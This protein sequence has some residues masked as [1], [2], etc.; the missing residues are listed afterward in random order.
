MR[1]VKWTK[2]ALVLAI[3]ALALLL[4]SGSTRTPKV[5][6][7]PTTVLTITNTLCLTLTAT[8]GDWN[9]DTVVDSADAQDGLS[10]CNSLSDAGNMADLVRVLGGDPDHP[11]PEDFATIDMDLGHLH[12]IDGVMYIVAFVT[13]DDPVTFYTDEGVF[14]RPNHFPPPDVLYGSSTSCGPGAAYDF[15]DADCD[16]NSATVGDGIVVARLVPGADPDRGPGTVRVRQGPL[17]EEAQ[18]TIVGEPHKIKLTV[19]KPSIQ[20]GANECKLLHNTAD[21][22]RIMGIPG[23][24]IIIATVTDDDGTPVTG[25]LVAFSTDDE[26]KATTAMTLTPSL[27][28]QALGVGAPNTL[29]GTVDSGTITVRAAITNGQAELGPGLDGA[30]NVG[31]DSEVEVTIQGIPTGMV[32]T[33]T[34]GSLACD[35]TASSTVSAALTDA[36]SKPAIDGT[37]VRFSA[38]TLGVVSPIEAKSA[39]GAATTTLTPLTGPMRGVALTATMMPDPIIDWEYLLGN[40][41]DLI[42]PVALA[43]LE[44]HNKEIS[45]R[46]VEEDE[47]PLTDV[48]M[49]GSLLVECTESAAPGAPSAPPSG[50]TPTAISPPATGDGGYSSGSQAISWWQ[51]LPLGLGVALLAGGLALRR[52]AR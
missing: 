15:E 10:K 34:P 32:L 38:K 24:T 45:W 42:D 44:H 4:L 52:R 16:S 25:G 48:P 6:A 11:K 12:E 47:L 51:T 43:D 35:G 17:E 33:A 26:N 41:R 13:N 39:G 1:A 9:D 8:D 20:D 31:K 23:T 2:V 40:Y 49:E 22:V 27:D 21:F 14:G 3:P 37:P 29:C 28:L 5:E 30:A 46:K 19:M 50:L 7:R 18:F 36:E